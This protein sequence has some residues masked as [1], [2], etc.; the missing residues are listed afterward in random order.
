MYVACDSWILGACPGVELVVVV[1]VVVVV[2][3]ILI[4]LAWS[5]LASPTFP[6]AS[7]GILASSQLAF[8]SSCLPSTLASTSE[9]QPL[10]LFQPV[11]ESEDSF[12]VVVV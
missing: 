7:P 8:H 2:A 10:D 9:R 11:E 12:L 3:A 6:D 4:I 1:E 5:P